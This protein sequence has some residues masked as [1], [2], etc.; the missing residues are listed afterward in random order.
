MNKISKDFT[1]TYYI[2]KLSNI[3]NYYKKD[4]KLMDNKN[5]IDVDYWID[6]NKQEVI[7]KIFVENN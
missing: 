3:I 4:L 1:N 6:I 5:I 2:S 7:F